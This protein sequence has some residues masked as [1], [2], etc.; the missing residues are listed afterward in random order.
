M[1]PRQQKEV[2]TGWVRFETGRLCPF[3]GCRV[4]AAHEHPVCPACGAVR[5]GNMSCRA[6]VAI[7]GEDPNPHRLLAAGPSE[8]I[9]ARRTL[10]ERL[11]YLAGKLT[12]GTDP[13]HVALALEAAADEM[14]GAAPVPPAEVWVAETWNAHGYDQIVLGVYASR[15]AAFRALKERPNMT[16]YTD[17][18]GHVKARPCREPSFN[19][20]VIA[21]LP[22]KWGRAFPVVVQT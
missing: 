22:V 12:E 21:Y 16:V 14:D 11:R 20:Q 19:D 3:L 8:V 7:R 15:E 1:K 2:S 18:S 17:D 6:C 13:V 9:L 4:E 5:Y 10:P